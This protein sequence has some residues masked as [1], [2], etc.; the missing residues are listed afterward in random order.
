MKNRVTRLSIDAPSVLYSAINE[1]GR[2][3]IREDIAS[4]IA[5]SEKYCNSIL[6]K[7]KEKLVNDSDSETLGSICEGLLHF[8]LTAALLPS[9]RKV[10]SRQYE[11][12]VIVPS[13]RL[14]EKE[15]Q[16]VLLIQVLKSS[17]GAARKISDA[18]ALQPV[19]DNIWVVAS[20]KISAGYRS[21]HFG[22]DNPTYSRIIIDIHD[23]VTKNRL[24]GLRLLHGE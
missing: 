22:F 24:S 13:L 2:R 23:F 21:Y 9:Q 7:C 11:I 19:R 5:L 15:P 20:K 17:K 8:M 18:E 4:N 6:G 3:K 12:D 14:L 16:K 10:T 1:I